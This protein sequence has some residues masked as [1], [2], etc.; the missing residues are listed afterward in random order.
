MQS[1]R[2]RKGDRHGI[3]AGSGIKCCISVQA[4]SLDLVELTELSEFGRDHF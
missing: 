3:T 4:G 2:P 1:E